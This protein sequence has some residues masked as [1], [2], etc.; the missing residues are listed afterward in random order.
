MRAKFRFQVT[1][2]GTYTVTSQSILQAC[3][4]IA[5][6][7]TNYQ[8]WASTVRLHRVRIYGIDPLIP[9]T[10]RLLWGNGGQPGVSRDILATDTSLGTAIPAVIDSKPPS[11][12]LAAMWMAYNT[13]RSDDTVFDFTIVGGSSTRAFVDIDV[14]YQLDML[15]PSIAAAPALTPVSTS[16]TAGQNYWASIVPGSSNVNQIVLNSFY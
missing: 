6:D 7:S 10:L 1:S 12:T 2:P 16:L 5:T 3:G 11:G 15:N 14:T 8:P 9:V 4:G 13:G